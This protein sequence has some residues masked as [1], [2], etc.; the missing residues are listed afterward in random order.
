MAYDYNDPE[1]GN[2]FSVESVKG[3]NPH[4]IRLGAGKILVRVLEV[5]Y[6]SAAGLVL[7]DN[8]RKEASSMGV[9]INAG[10]G[11][12]IDWEPVS[13]EDGSVAYCVPVFGIQQVEVGDVV[14]FAQH[15]GAVMTFE[16][17]RRQGVKYR[18][19]DGWGD[20]LVTYPPQDVAA[21]EDADAG[22]STVGNGSSSS[23]SDD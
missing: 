19:L 8:A 1:W 7:P 23:G 12:R 15:V 20:V 11:P 16:Q 17:D 3:M 10:I 4:N 22:G 18:I 21:E 14:L 5:E 13:G 2:G 9:V 6:F